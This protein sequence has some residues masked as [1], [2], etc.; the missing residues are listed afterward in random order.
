MS[1]SAANTDPL[2]LHVKRRTERVCPYR[3]LRD[4]RYASRGTRDSGN[5]A[6]SRMNNAGSK[7]GVMKRRRFLTVTMGALVLGGLLVAGVVVQTRQRARREYRP[8]CRASPRTGTKPCRRRSGSSS[9]RPSTARRCWI[10]K[11][12]W[13]GRGPRRRRA[14]GGAWPA[15]PASRKVSEARKAGGCRTSK[16]WPVWW[17]PL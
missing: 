17:I 6:A 14:P 9:C 4:T 5:F 15:V 11:P 13:S 8:I 2:F 7:E 3:R 1:V 16:S 12:A 10:K